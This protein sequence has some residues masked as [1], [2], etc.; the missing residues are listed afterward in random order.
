[1]PTMSA[2]KLPCGCKID[3]VGH[4]FMIQPCSSDCEYYRYTLAESRRQGKPVNAVVDPE[5]GDVDL[6][7]FGL[8]PTNEGGGR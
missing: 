6:A 4:T 8:G 5:L 2:M 1:M 7:K 3:N